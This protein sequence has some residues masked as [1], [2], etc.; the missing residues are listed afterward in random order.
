MSTKVTVTL[1]VEL[2]DDQ[3]AKL[4]AYYRAAGINADAPDLLSCHVR[5]CV[6]N[7]SMSP[8]I[9][10]FKYSNDL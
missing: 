4:I 2:D 8:K 1:G 5:D 6:E 10:L 9:V 3:T 7:S